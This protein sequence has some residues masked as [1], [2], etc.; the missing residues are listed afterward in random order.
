[1]L[2]CLKSILLCLLLSVLL[3]CDDQ[4]S[5]KGS[6]NEKSD[7]IEQAEGGQYAENLKGVLSFNLLNL[8]ETNGEIVFFFQGEPYLRL[9]KQFVQVD[10]VKCD[11]YVNT[12]DSL[13]LSSIVF[14][15]EYDLFVV[16]CCIQNSP[17]SFYVSI[18]SKVLSLPKNNPYVH[19]ETFEEHLKGKIV[20]LDQA[21]LVLRNPSDST[22]VI[23]N[24]EDYVFEIVEIKENWLYL[25]PDN[26]QYDTTFFGWAKFKE[27]DSLTIVP[28]YVY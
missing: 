20:S 4:E 1:M 10:K 16:S 12:C 7:C 17:D 14:N 13:I 23:N 15:P 9:D 28:S 11:Y 6:N 18:N 26:N 8:K 25:K 21:N 2:I 3:S 27:G 19:F 5:K 22:S 24:S